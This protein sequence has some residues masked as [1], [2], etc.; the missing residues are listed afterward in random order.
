MPS[1]S[2][3]GARDFKGR[4]GSFWSGSRSLVGVVVV[5]VLFLIARPGTRQQNSSNMAL[6]IS[7]WR[8]SY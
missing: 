4:F 5:A 2:H 1:P 8:N 7:K 3:L 6:Y